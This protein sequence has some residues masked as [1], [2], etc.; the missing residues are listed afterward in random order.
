MFPLLTVLSE[1][2]SQIQKPL[3]NRIFQHPKSSRPTNYSQHKYTNLVGY[4]HVRCFVLRTNHDG[5]SCRGNRLKAFSAARYE[6]Q[7][8]DTKRGRSPSEA[9]RATIHAARSRYLGCRL[10]GLVNSSKSPVS[11]PANRNFHGQKNRDDIKANHHRIA[12][13]PCWTRE[14]RIAHAELFVTVA[15]WNLHLPAALATR[16]RVKSNVRS[17]IQGFT[18]NVINRTLQCI[19]TFVIW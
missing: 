1:S 18:S 15:G 8:H 14:Y 9:A 13:P 10:L 17:P 4:L 2:G 3:F 11:Q 7:R 6:K 12:K 5:R 19:S 16:D